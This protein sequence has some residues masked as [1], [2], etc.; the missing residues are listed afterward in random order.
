MKT[1]IIF[2]RGETWFTEGSS[3]TSAK[4]TTPVEYTVADL[5]TVSTGHAG[6]QI[7]VFDVAID[8]DWRYYNLLGTVEKAL[9]AIEFTNAAMRA[10]YL[11]DALADI[12]IARVIVRTSQV[13]CPYDGTT[14]YDLLDPMTTEWTTHQTDAVYDHAALATTALSGAGITNGT[15]SANSCLSD[16]SFDLVWRHELGH[17]WGSGD[18]HGSAPEG[19]MIMDGNDRY[20]FSG[21]SVESMFTRRDNLYFDLDKIDRSHVIGPPYAA[22]D[23]VT[24]MRGSG[25]V[26]IDSMGND[27]DAKGH[28]LS[29]QSYE[30]TSMLGQAVTLSAGTGPGG[31]DELIYAI[32][33]D[34]VGLDYFHYTIV[35]DIGQTATGVVHVNIDT[36]D[37]CVRINCEPSDSSVYG[38]YLPDTGLVYADRGKGYSYGWDADISADMMDRTNIRGVPIQ[39]YA[40]MQVTGNRTWEIGLANGTYNLTVVCGDIKFANAAVNNLDIEGTIVNDPD[41]QDY[42]DRYFLTV[43]VA[44]EHLTISP[45]AGASGVK[46]CYVHIAESSP[47]CEGY[48]FDGDIDGDCFVGIMDLWLLAQDW[49]LTSTTSFADINEDGDVDMLDFSYMGRDWLTEL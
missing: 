6:N 31:R 14:G 1:R 13:H 16:G 29:L 21:C 22:L 11:R 43:T 17:S 7:Y 32:P 45:A 8:S 24:V 40:Q 12:R 3:V 36:T 47:P 38:D 35:D 4:G 5:P 26:A 15:Y 41:G 20:R 46:L 44:D 18:W 42:I 25:T 27:H 23:R 48:H 28:G 2:E 39:T 34:I 49:L 9:E 33:G 37:F 10:V 19:K 30:T